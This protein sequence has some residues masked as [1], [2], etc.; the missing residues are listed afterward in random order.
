MFSHQ[1]K[2]SHQL[3]MH[4]GDLEYLKDIDGCIL[5]LRWNY[6]GFDLLRKLSISEIFQIVVNIAM[7]AFY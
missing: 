5:H 2:A 7:I 3:G 1:T 4:M 6:M